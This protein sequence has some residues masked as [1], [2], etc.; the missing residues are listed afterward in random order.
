LHAF[1]EFVGFSALVTI[2]WKSQ[3]CKTWNV[4]QCSE[5]YYL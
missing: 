2:F 4:N 5:D 1:I 3:T